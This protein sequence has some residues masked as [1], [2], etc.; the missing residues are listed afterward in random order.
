MSLRAGAPGVLAPARTTSPAAGLLF[1]LVALAP[2]SARTAAPVVHANLHLAPAASDPVDAAAA[3]RASKEVAAGKAAFARGDAAAAIVRFEAAL[4]LRP[5]PGLHYNLGV[6]HM[7]LYNQAGE[8]RDAAGEA[9]HAAAA[10]EAFNTYLRAVPGAK[11]RAEVEALIRGLGGEPATA[12]QLRDPL[13]APPGPH[14]DPEPTGDGPTAKPL[15]EQPSGDGPQPVPAPAATS[16]PVLVAPIPAPT[17]TYAPPRGYLG[18]ALGLASQPQLAART[19]LDGAYQ[20]LVSLRG[21]ARLGPR[22]RAELGAQVWLAVPGETAKNRLALS[23]QSLLLDAGYAIPL[24]RTHRLELPVGG[25]IGVARE[26][27]RTRVDQPLPGCAIQTMTAALAGARAGG[28][29]GG[30]LGFAVLVGPRRNHELGMQL[31]LAFFGFG[32]RF[33]LGPGCLSQDV[34]RARFVLT[35]VAGYAFRF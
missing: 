11:D 18:V 30:R 26:A 24:G 3:E 33:D 27:L 31:S 29:A 32:P 25:F 17:Q 16:T 34:P 14:V 15:S 35:G 4:A 8:R 7:R 5:A 22:R 28:V 12:A 10:I 1:A 19:D 2:A 20:G 6:C 23:T 9:R 21:G 13:S